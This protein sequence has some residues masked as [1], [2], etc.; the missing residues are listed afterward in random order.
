MYFFENLHCRVVAEV[1]QLCNVTFMAMA[2]VDGLPYESTVLNAMKEN[3]SVSKHLFGNA[4]LDIP[5]KVAVQLA[6]LCE[7]FETRP[8]Y[9]PATTTEPTA[10]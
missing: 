2:G 5:G 3:G 1:S 4:E 8:A 10:P 7:S 6:S 9:L